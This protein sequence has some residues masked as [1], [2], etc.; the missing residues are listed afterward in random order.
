MNSN[1]HETSILQN[2]SNVFLSNYDSK[3]SYKELQ[4]SNM[5][6]FL[7]KE[8]KHSKSESWNKMDKTEK[9][10][11]LN[12]YVDSIITKYSLTK[13]DV[14]E[15]KK[16]LIGKL[17]TIGL[18]RVKDV[19]YNKTTGEII[20]IPRLLFNSTNRK[21]TLKKEE[22]RQSSTLKSLGKGKKKDTT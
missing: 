18:R 3:D 2:S 20:S 19:E 14:E 12:N 21:F 17:D 5:N 10:K 15:L 1:S 13:N 16:Y 4:I 6:S 7:D 8:T 11:L 22:K 9:I